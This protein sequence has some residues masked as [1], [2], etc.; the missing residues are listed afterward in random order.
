[1]AK[2][3]TLK[4]PSTLSTLLRRLTYRKL[5]LEILSS[6]SVGLGETLELTSRL[7]FGYGGEL[8]L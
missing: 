4:T 7:L 5:I 1:M 2:T 6:T 8:S 3:M